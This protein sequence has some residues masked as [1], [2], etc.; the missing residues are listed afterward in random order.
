MTFSERR[1]RD[2]KIMSSSRKK[3][4]GGYPSPHKAQSS[5]SSPPKIAGSPA[6]SVGEKSFYRIASCLGSSLRRMLGWLWFQ[7]KRTRSYITIPGIVL[8]SSVLMT[9]LAGGFYF[10][11]RVTVDSSGPYDPA[12][13][14][15]LTFTVTNTN[16]VPLRDVHFGIG[17]CYLDP[18]PNPHPD[19]NGPAESRLIFTSWTIKWL[20]VDEKYQIAIEDAIKVATASGAQ[21]VQSAN[22]TIAVIYTPWRMPSF[23]KST[24][25]FRFITKRRSDGKI[26]WVPT[27]L[28]R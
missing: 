7:I 22:I 9:L 5:H 15:P 11:P 4:K 17:V 20:D 18:A 28:N 8:W 25:E 3:G 26:Y 6:S 2:A 24:K 27:P 21:Q 14:S 1:L 12:N 19:C 10:L 23:W 13:P 16:I